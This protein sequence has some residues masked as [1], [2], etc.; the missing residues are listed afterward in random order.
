MLASLNKN[1]KIVQLLLQATASHE[2][3]K[4]LT[5]QTN[6]NWMTPLHASCL[7]GAIEITETLLK[8]GADI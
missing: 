5:N 7:L 1:L 2:E 6:K 8:Q 4:T 3:S